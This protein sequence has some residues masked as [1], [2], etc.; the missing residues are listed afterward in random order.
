MQPFQLK[1]V[2]VS[3]DDYDVLIDDLTMINMIKSVRFTATMRLQPQEKEL[4]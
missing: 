3:T 2:P 4:L 1:R